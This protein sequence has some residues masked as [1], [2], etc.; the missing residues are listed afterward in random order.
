M[1]VYSQHSKYFNYVNRDV[2]PREA[3]IID[4]RDEILQL[5]ETGTHLII[6]LDGNEDMRSGHLSKALTS[7]HLREA[8]FQKHGNT[9]PSTYRRNTKDVPID[10]IWIS[11]SL[12]ILKGGYLDFDEVIFGTD[13]HT[14]WVDISFT[15]AFGHTGTPPIVRPSAQRLNNRNPKVRNKFNALRKE[16]ARKSFLTTRTTQL[17][18]SIQGEM[19]SAQIREY[20]TIDRLR[21]QHIKM[22]ENRC[23]K[24]RCGNIPYSTTIQEARNKI[25]AWSLLLRH[26]KG[27]RI[28]SRKLE[29]TMKKAGIPPSRKSDLL[30]IIQDELTIAY[31]K[32]YKLKKYAAQLRETHLE[33]LA[34]TLATQGN[35][36][37]SNILK[38]L[39]TREAQHSTARKIKYLRGK[40]IRNSTT[41]V[42]IKQN[43]GTSV[44]ITEK[45]QMEKAIIKSNKKKFQ[46][47]F[48][49]PFYKHPYNQLFGYQGLTT[50]SQ[51]VLDGNFTPPNNAS[52]YMRD[53][54]THLATPYRTTQT[55]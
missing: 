50:A 29:H 10:G 35:L 3:F 48:G 26:K 40:L 9:T 21:R 30:L 46:Q 36:K 5:Q 37:K 16:Y 6:M 55:I 43:N 20:E 15:S 28:S 11:Q 2:F 49:T 25:E 17:E 44:D 47:S 41:M 38:Q 54:L 12:D 19:N 8:I 24:F 27:L 34:S 51:Q 39:R 53:F 4:L 22:A 45:R 33:N 32:Y 14:L 7:L 1:G 42:S 31:K 52:T 18:L 23:R 13:H